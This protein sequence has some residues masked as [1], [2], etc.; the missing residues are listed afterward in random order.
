MRSMKRNKAV[1]HAALKRAT[2][3]ALEGRQLL[4]AVDTSFLGTPFTPNQT[5][6]AANYDKGGE[7]VSYHDTTPTNL[8][9]D[10]YRPGDAV[11]I[12]A[13][14]STGKVVGYTAAGEWLNYTVNIPT[15]GAF[16]LH[17]S[18]DNVQSG[19]SF[20]AAVA[21]KNVTGAIAIPASPDWV[22]H[23]QRLLKQAQ[24]KTAAKDKP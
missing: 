22:K 16:T 21:G 18:V 14:G 3:E 10:N 1:H 7:G 4:T 15:A 17:A 24:S 19:A 13:G 2:V 23:A 8:G 20:H 12:K 9:G 11:D 6:L 5:I